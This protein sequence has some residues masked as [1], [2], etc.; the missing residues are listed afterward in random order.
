VEHGCIIFSRI[1]AVHWIGSELAKM[2]LTSQ[3]PFTPAGRRDISG[4][5]CFSGR[6][7][8]KAAVKQ[9]FVW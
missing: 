6:E 1:M 4:E 5:D 3:W 9:A 8:I 2:L 7:G